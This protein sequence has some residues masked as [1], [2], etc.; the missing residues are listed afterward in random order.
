MRY[1]SAGRL[2]SDE[3]MPPELSPAGLS[4]FGAAHSSLLAWL[5]AQSHGIRWGVAR[6]EFARTLYRSAEHR[7]GGELPPGA[8]LENYLRGL[9]LEDL[10]MACALRRG[11]EPAW[12]EFVARYRPMLYA[13]A[14]AI[15]GAAGEAR[16]RELADSLYAELYGLD[17]EGG[18][19]AHSLLDYFHGRSRLATWLRA[20]LTQRHIDW[21]RA[22]RRTGPLDD[23]QTAGGGDRQ[24]PAE[25]IAADPDRKRLLPRLREAVS[26]ALAALTPPERLLIS[27]YYVEELTLAQI[28]RLRG[29]HEATA[30][31][32][33]ERI[34]RE[35]R[36]R[37]EQALA[38]DRPAE[39]GL[40]GQA[41]L[42]PEEIRLCF[43]YA[44][45]DWPFNL[46]QTLS[47]NPAPGNSGE[48]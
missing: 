35:L 47:E 24:T 38:A 25:G 37:I 19:R 32:Q 31:R 2:M 12:E 20:I 5:H 16:A 26:G 27:L 11:A 43:S 45:E 34:R 41:G 23:E 7:F 36:E 1:D 4:E 6:E 40:A 22:A 28:A 18:E 42:S 9:H 39:N 33:L 21:L 15:V 8:A 29:M 10:A 3:S 17:R 30:S 13:A 46:R 48:I 14:R 44:L